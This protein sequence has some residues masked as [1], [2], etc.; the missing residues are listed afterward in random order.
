MTRVA[1][2]N[3]PIRKHRNIR[4][5]NE[6]I[7]TP[8][9]GCSIQRLLKKIYRFLFFLLHSGHNGFRSNQIAHVHHIDENTRRYFFIS[10]ANFPLKF[11]EK[12]PRFVISPVL[13]FV[14]LCSLFCFKKKQIR[15][16]TPLSWPKNDINYSTLTKTNFI[17][18]SGKNN[19]RFTVVF[20]VFIQSITVLY[21]TIIHVN[22]YIF[23][24]IFNWN[25]NRIIMYT[26][27]NDPS[28]IRY[29]IHGINS[30]NTTNGCS[31]I[32]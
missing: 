14:S 19:S 31:Y 21:Y 7:K 10:H 27:F 23:F 6:I 24:C 25:D 11:C 29:A 12:N 15:N 3:R 5:F 1:A 9:F 28:W 13:P 32:F 16:T 2:C 20:T 17:L 4:R 18:D 30:V 8:R 22:V 26:H